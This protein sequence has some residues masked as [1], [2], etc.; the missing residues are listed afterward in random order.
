MKEKRK[1]QYCGRRPIGN[2]L[3]DIKIRINAKVE[4]KMYEDR[5]TLKTVPASEYGSWVVEYD[6]E[7]IEAQIKSQIKWHLE[8]VLDGKGTRVDLKVGGNA[9]IGFPSDMHVRLIG[10]D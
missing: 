6:R 10:Q 8:R 1:I 7:A 3:V 9:L 2:L 4:E 5:L